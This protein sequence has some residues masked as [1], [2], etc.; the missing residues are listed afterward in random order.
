MAKFFKQSGSPRR[1]ALLAG[2][3]L[4]VFAAGTATASAEYGDAGIVNDAPAF[5]LNP[6]TLEPGCF[7]PGQGRHHNGVDVDSHIDVTQRFGNAQITIKDGANYSVDQ[8]L[9]PGYRTGYAV[10]NR[11]DTGSINNDQDIDPTQTA[12][13]MSAPSNAPIDT[14]G[15]IVCVSDHPDGDQNEPYISDGLPGEVAAVNR[16]IIQPT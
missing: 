4:A 13:D 2:T 7:L 3:S 6:H 15:V 1:L 9:V 5:R 16:P 11:F 8:V 12:T 14:Y 10:Y